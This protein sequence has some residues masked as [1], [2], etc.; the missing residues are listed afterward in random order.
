MLL[1]ELPS[2]TTLVSPGVWTDP[3]SRSRYYVD[4]TDATLLLT[5]SWTP[6]ETEDYS[7]VQD[8]AAAEAAALLQAIGDRV[9]L[10]QG[11]ATVIST[12]QASQTA[13]ADEVALY[14]VEV[15]TIAAIQAEMVQ[16]H[17]DMAV[18]GGG[19]AQV[20]TDTADLAIVV[21]GTLPGAP[22]G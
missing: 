7:A 16:M 20:L 14:P 6:K 5:R 11:E 18:L 21:S 12:F 8:T 22:V 17:R 9:T 3:L 2:T 1:S 19:L 4:P 10:L 15:I 13:R